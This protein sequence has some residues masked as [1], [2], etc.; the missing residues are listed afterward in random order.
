[1]ASEEELEELQDM[2]DDLLNSDGTDSQPGQGRMCSRNSVISNDRVFS[3]E[4]NF[5][6]R[7]WESKTL[8]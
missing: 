6:L 5:V 1:M 4:R 3:F 7:R 8:K 2:V